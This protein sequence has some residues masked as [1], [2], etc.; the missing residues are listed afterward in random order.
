MIGRNVSLLV[1]SVLVLAMP[2][3]AKAGTWTI[4]G[5]P[6]S[7]PYRMSFSFGQPGVSYRFECQAN[8]MSISEFGVTQLM[9]VQTGVKISD[10]PGATITPGASVMGVYTDKVETQLV[11][12]TA[13]ANPAKGWDLTIVVPL[14][15]PA[16]RS[17]SKAGMVSL[18]TTGWTGAV[19]LSSDDRKVIATFL[20]QCHA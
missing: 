16:L 12:A 4:E 5:G 18:M 17:M 9:D 8:Q 11:P 15:D 20:G 10:E 1:W 13:I 6:N 2:V 3:A 14:T 7:P 19:E